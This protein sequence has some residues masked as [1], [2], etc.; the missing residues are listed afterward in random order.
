MA[1]NPTMA[2]LKKVFSSEAVKNAVADYL[3][4][5]TFAEVTKG[6]VDPVLNQ[7][8]AELKPR[9]NLRAIQHGR[10]E[11]ITD[12]EHL[13]L[14]EDEALFQHYL[15]LAD[16][17][18]KAAGIKPADMERDWC[19]YLVAKHE[20]VKAEWALIDATGAPFGISTD[21]PLYGENRQKWLD[22]VV[23]AALA[24]ERENA[25]G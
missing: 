17:R 16:E 1:K 11:L 14:C 23:G 19:P 12:H 2:Q 8:V 7:I 18:L 5:R 21:S 3:V 10:D 24:L 4:K 15:D 25:H 13:Y 20:L 9:A 6:L 22:L